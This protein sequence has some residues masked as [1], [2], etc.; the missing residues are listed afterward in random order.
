MEISVYKLYFEL[1][2]K[3][4]TNVF[5][6]IQTINRNLAKVIRGTKTLSHQN[7]HLN[8]FELQFLI[9]LLLK[10]PAFA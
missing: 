3:L 6:T 8:F 9:Q 10:N 4:Q 7:Y 2:M 1:V 5:C